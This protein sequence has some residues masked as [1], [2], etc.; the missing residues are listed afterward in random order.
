MKS[1]PGRYRLL[2]VGPCLVALAACNLTSN[3]TGDFAP[4]PPRSVILR[5][6]ASGLTTK[7]VVLHYAGPA[8][9]ARD[10]SVAANGT[11]TFGAVP[12]GTYAVTVAEQPLAKICT[13][14]NGS[15]T[16]NEDVTNVTV[17]CIQDPNAPVYKVSGTVKNV[18]APAAG[19]E[20]QIQTPDG[21]EKIAA[22]NGAFQFNSEL[23]TDY[24]Y[25]VTVA[26]K[27]SVPDPFGGPPVQHNCAVNAG[28]GAI[29]DSN[30]TDVE[31]VCGFTVGGTVA[32]NGPP[33]TIGAGM[34][35]A[36]VSAGTTVET[37]NYAP[38][39]AS[40]QFAGLQPS[41]ASSNVYVTVA[42]QPAGQV[43]VVRRAGN[44]PLTTPADVTNIAVLCQ[45]TPITANQLAGTY[46][47]GRNFLTFFAD[48]TFL[49]GTHSAT[50][51]A[52][53]VEHGLYLNNCCGQVGWLLLTVTTDTNGSA[54]ISD[55]AV[56]MG[57]VLATGVT[58]SAG[59]PAQIAFTANPFTTPTPYTFT[60]ADSISGQLQ[61]AWASGDKLRV[62]AYSAVDGT[63]FHYGV[64]NGAGNVQDQCLTLGA[65]VQGT[66]TGS[67]VPNLTPATCTI[68]GG[69]APINVD[70]SGGA[71]AFPGTPGA[72]GALTVDYT[73]TAGPPNG[74]SLQ[75][76]F[77]GGPFGPP[78][79]FTRSEIN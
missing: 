72:F 37:L 35:L 47:F 79:G 50:A 8:G 3:S 46:K 43:C 42:T 4:A 19:L 10:L 27:P 38:A 51:G 20:L 33:T 13:V 9:S 55:A 53:G 32:F 70:P 44:A 71:A 58:K 14:T 5:G 65:P 21:T 23:L 16:A 17:T 18:I 34:Q 76:T 24:T 6:T 61:G 2:A 26:T 25:E 22:A 29:L 68:P 52:T 39:V 75:P 62:F 73:L 66:A 36:L 57:S 49:Y 1:I 41:T 74:L 48:G 11:F 31:V 54:G 59:P 60:A 7:P 15:G 28:S 12:V 30:I 45:D 69:L 63:V 64:N 67:Y 56:D 78:V 40:F 77:F